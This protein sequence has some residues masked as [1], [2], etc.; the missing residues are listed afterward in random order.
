[1]REVRLLDRSWSLGSEVGSGG[2]GVVVEAASEGMG[3][4]VAKFVPKDPG[5]VR[6]LLFVDLEGVR[7]V[8]PVI[9]SG[10]LEITGSWSCPG[11]SVRSGIV[12]RR[13]T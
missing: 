13:A 9:D 5:A 7:N 4:C 1:M 3:Q 11:Q 8:V 6:E 2:F 12:L 10:K